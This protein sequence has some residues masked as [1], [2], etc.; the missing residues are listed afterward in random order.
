MRATIDG[1]EAAAAVAEALEREGCRAGLAVTDQFQPS[2]WL[3][4]T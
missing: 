4:A 3:E 2:P 1:N